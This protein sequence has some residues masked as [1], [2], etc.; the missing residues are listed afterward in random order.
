M[1]QP[2]GVRRVACDIQPMRIKVLVCDAQELARTGVR[3]AL[4]SA[5]DL[6]VVG[7]AAG[8]EDVLARV[9]ELAPQVVLMDVVMPRGNGIEAT[10]RIVADQGG[11][12]VLA[13][14]MHSDPRYV[15]AML[16]AGALGYVLKSRAYEEL[17]GAIRAVMAGGTYLSPGLGMRPRRIS[18]ATPLAV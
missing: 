2:P 10:R 8:G 4:E 11:V 13:L 14:S 7:E 1:F 6:E 17:A 18:P 15:W 5:P 3:F 9:R 16:E 12:K